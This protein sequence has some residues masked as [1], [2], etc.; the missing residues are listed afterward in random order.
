VGNHKRHAKRATMSDYLRCTFMAYGEPDC[1]GYVAIGGSLLRL[2]RGPEPRPGS[3]GYQRRR[4]M[5]RLARYLRLVQAVLAEPAGLRGRGD[6]ASV[7][8]SLPASSCSTK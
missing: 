5:S 6:V 4:G 3:R 8:S 7:V 2:P 1:F